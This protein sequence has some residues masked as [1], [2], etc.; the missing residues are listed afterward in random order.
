MTRPA[1]QRRYANAVWGF[2]GAAIAVMVIVVY[3]MGGGHAKAGST[4][5]AA[6]EQQ[7]GLSSAQ[8]AHVA[9]LMAKLRTQPKDVPTLV[10]LGDVFFEAHEYNSAGGWMKRA[11]EADPNDVTARVA[12]GAAEFNIGDAADAGRDW[13]RAVAADPKNVE[14]FYDL[15]FMYVSRQP[16]DMKDAKK[17]WAKVVE[18]APN[19]TVA[20]TVATHIKGL[21]KK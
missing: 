21:E 12:L 20:K 3:N 13:R 7:H 19:S 15:G 1:R 16:P 18:L 6:A 17:M 14:A 10:A 11:V 9:R 5:G 8:R 4:Q 2:A